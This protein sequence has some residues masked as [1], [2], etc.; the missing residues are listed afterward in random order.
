MSL[1]GTLQSK[2]QYRI[3]RSKCAVFVR[4]DFEDIGVYNSI[5]R[6]L[7]ELVKEG[8]LLHLGYGAYARAKKSSI[9]G[10]LIPEIPLRD[11]A[12][13][14]MKKLKIKPMPS[15]AD[16]AYNKGLTTQ[17]PTGRVIGV[18]RRVSRKLGYNGAY[19]AFEKVS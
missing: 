18:N 9:S 1:K 4:K 13:E 19:V 2:I 14:T 12:I 11:L 6:I 10:Q 8:Q 7:K 16:Q 3:K 17:V 5:G 15:S